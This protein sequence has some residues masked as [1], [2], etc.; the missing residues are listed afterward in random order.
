MAGDLYV[1]EVG[2]SIGSDRGCPFV[3]L[4]DRELKSAEQKV[5]VEFP[6]FGGEAGY[7]KVWSAEISP[8][9]KPGALFVYTLRVTLVRCRETV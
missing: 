9:H 8:P 2:S 6:D 7:W 3:S 1:D 4:C 5:L